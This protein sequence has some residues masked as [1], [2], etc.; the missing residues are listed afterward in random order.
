MTKY[1]IVQKPNGWYYASKKLFGIFNIWI[2]GYVDGTSSK[3]IDNCEEYL[4]RNLSTCSKAI[5]EINI[6]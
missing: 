3:S 1:I 6:K 4:R 5:K 2:G